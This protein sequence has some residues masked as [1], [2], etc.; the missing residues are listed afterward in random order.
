MVRWLA[1]LLVVCVG[2]V[3]VLSSNAYCLE[4]L[5]IKNSV[6][7]DVL[8]GSD[9]FEIVSVGCGSDSI[10]EILDLVVVRR[11][12]ID[13][14]II[15]EGYSNKIKNYIV[16]DGVR[17]NIQLCESGDDLIIGSPLIKSSF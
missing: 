17:I 7:Y 6:E 3:F 14:K 11:F 1:C 10:F 13:N 5:L 9:N 16:V 8:D 15:V 12:E 4:N 2:G